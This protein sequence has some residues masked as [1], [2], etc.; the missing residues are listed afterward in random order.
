MGA[1]I[2]GGIGVGAGLGPDSG[3]TEVGVLDAFTRGL[4]GRGG[5]VEMKEEG[6]EEDV[7]DD[8]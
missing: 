2:G 7:R 5:E 6:G 1:G 4:C 8:L 3:E